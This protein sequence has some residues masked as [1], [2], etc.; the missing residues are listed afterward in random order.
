[1][2]FRVTFAAWISLYS[3]LVCIYVYSIFFLEWSVGIL[4]CV[5][6]K[7]RFLI[8][9]PIT[10]LI[11][12]ALLQSLQIEIS[13]FYLT[14]WKV[15]KFILYVF[16]S[17]PIHS[18]STAWLHNLTLKYI[19]NLPLFVIATTTWCPGNHFI[20]PGYCDNY[21]VCLPTC[22]LSCPPTYC[23]FS[24]QHPGWLFYK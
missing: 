3:K 7:I 17:L 5:C 2:A 23:S 15:L 22:L 6:S 20:W 1:M 16:A 21:F 9:S 8:F 14:I 4:N 12:V 10:N 19:H 18:Q 13:F 24:M 11:L